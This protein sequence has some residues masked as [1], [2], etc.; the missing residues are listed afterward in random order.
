MLT[1]RKTADKLIGLS[2]ILSSLGLLFTVAVILIDVIGRAFGKPL[3]GSQDLVTMSMVILVFGAMAQCERTGG[4]LS[5]D[6]LGHRFSGLFNRIIDVVSALLGAAIFAAVAYATY[7][8]AKL[9]IMLNLSTNLLGL[10]KVWFQG[11]VVAFSIVTA[12]G[13]ALR[14]AELAFIDFDVRQNSR[15][16]K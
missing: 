10:P 11:A 9:S 16:V 12:I 15:V 14:A 6:L 7:E 1:L 4:H 5:V 13:L 8:S 3:F 2:A